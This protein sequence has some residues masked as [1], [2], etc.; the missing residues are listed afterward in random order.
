L[1]GAPSK[2]TGP[3]PQ[4]FQPCALSLLIPRESRLP[5][6]RSLGRVLPSTQE[7]IEKLVAQQMEEIKQ[8]LDSDSM[9][10]QRSER[11]RQI[12]LADARDIQ[13]E[14]IYAFITVIFLKDLH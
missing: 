12:T 3:S 8:L 1:P 4:E 13:D 5:T 6:V 10:Q 7:G 11:I 9:I 14:L 2:Y